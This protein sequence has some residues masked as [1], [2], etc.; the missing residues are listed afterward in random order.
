MAAKQ[1]YARRCRLGNWFGYILFED[2]ECMCYV[3]DCC[4][5]PKNAIIVN[6]PTIWL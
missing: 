3:G 6:L 4:I 1:I 5:L 2:K